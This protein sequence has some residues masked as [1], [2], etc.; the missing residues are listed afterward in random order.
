VTACLS[1]AHWGQN[2]GGRRQRER[3]FAEHV[4]AGRERCRRQFLVRGRRHA[5]VHDVHVGMANERVQVGRS[6]D[7]GHVERLGRAGDVAPATGEIAG[8]ALPV[9]VRDG[10]ELRAGDLAERADVHAPHE[11]QT[12]DADACH[13]ISP[14]GSRRT[15]TPS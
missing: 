3:L 1:Q 15:D 13:V 9:K 14:A 8:R 6:G 11:T 10:D 5:D 7:A 4:F 2:G 12:D